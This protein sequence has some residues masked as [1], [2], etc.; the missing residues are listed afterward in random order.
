MRTLVRLRRA[1]EQLDPPSA[2][3]SAAEATDPQVQAERYVFTE[4]PR[5]ERD[6]WGSGL[7]RHLE[8]HGFGKCSRSLCVFCPMLTKKA[9]AQPWL[10]GSWTPR[11]SRRRPRSSG[12]TWRR[13]PRPLTPT[14]PSRAGTLHRGEARA[15]GAAAARGTGTGCWWTSTAPACG[16]CVA[17]H[18][19]TR[20]GQRSTAARARSPS[21]STARSCGGRGT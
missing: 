2:R 7:V 21:P 14:A 13:G 17:R 3:P 12:I 5:F 4:A 1:L 18:V 6:E 9:A 10:P 19:C 20:C 16:T 15:S 11:K 8:E